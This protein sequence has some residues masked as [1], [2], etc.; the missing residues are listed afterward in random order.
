MLWASSRMRH[1]PVVGVGL[2]NFRA[3]YDSYAGSAPHFR[4]YDRAA[5]NAYLEVWAETGI[6]GLGL[7][8]IAIVAQLKE[9]I[10]AIVARCSRDYVLLSAEAACYGL[11]V[12]GLF[13]SV[14]W[15]KSFWLG[16][17]LL[18][19]VLQRTNL[20]APRRE[21]LNARSDHGSK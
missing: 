11:L 19:I 14:Q 15:R 13:G 5:H 10:R 3:A 21:D 20:A 17:L 4:G 12:Y 2:G 9:A 7:L 16:W 18:A 8:L 1:N 6:I